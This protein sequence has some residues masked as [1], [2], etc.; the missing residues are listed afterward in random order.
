VYW[1]RIL[2]GAGDTVSKRTFWLYHGG[3][4]LGATQADHDATDE[5]VRLLAIY[6]EENFPLGHDALRRET[7]NDFRQKLA[8]AMV[9]TFDN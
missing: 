8:R 6:R 1:L 3:R 4:V 9:K 2:P 5:E 7:P